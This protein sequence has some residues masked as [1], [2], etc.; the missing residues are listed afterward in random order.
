[1]KFVKKVKNSLKKE[2]DSEPVY[3]K[4]YLK[5]K[6]KSY[7]RKINTHFHNN[8]IPKESSQITCLSVNLIDSSFRASKNYY[9]QLFL[10]EYLEE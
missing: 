1:M 9:P 10:E 5:P 4:K 3:N 2:F 8:K 7:H 6:I